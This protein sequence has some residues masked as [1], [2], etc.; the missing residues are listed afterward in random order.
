MWRQRVHCAARPHKACSVQLHGP[1]QKPRKC[2]WGR[3]CTPP[4]PNAVQ[5]APPRSSRSCCCQ[6]F[7]PLRSSPHSARTSPP[8]TARSTPRLR[9]SICRWD[10]CQRSVR[11]ARRHCRLHSGQVRTRSSARTPCASTARADRRTSK[12][13]L[14]MRLCSLRCRPPRQAYRAEPEQLQGWRSPAGYSPCSVAEASRVVHTNRTRGIDG[15][16]RARRARLLF[17]A[18]NARPRSVDDIYVFW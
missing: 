4:T 11:S 7:R 10:N 2:P 17:C 5:S 6:R 15:T 12:S 8:G 13:R 14:A 1:S 18:V 9:A 16:T 3:Q